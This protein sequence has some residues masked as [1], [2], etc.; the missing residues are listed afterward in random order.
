MFLHVSDTVLHPRAPIPRED[1]FHPADPHPR[2]TAPLRDTVLPERTL[3][4]RVTARAP[5]R[6]VA[7]AVA[8][9]AAR[10]AFG[11]PDTRTLTRTLTSHDGTCHGEPLHRMRSAAQA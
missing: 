5:E 3:A 9:R 8:F 1:A 11:N 4:Q 7:V 2:D 10:S 6:A